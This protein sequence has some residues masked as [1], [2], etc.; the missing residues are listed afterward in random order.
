M[1]RPKST[2][3]LTPLELE[4]MMVL[5]KTDGAS[6]QTVLDA[7]PEGRNLTYS[8]VQTMLN[9]LVRKGKATR[10]LHGRAF[11]YHPALV[12][13]SAVRSALKDLIDRMFGGS[14]EDLVVGLVE[15]EQ[16]DAGKLMELHRTLRRREEKGDGHG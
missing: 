15:T 3:E 4:L 12:R 2:T 7:L 11:Q 9:L 14:A 10:E 13:Q 1:A 8:T 16:L 5:W 6:V